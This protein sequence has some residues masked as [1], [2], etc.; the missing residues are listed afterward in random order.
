[1]ALEEDIDDGMSDYDSQLDQNNGNLLGSPTL[2][3][4]DVKIVKSD[5]D[6]NP[7]GYNIILNKK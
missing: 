4:H 5:D 2:R 1:M 6:E 7:H 3:L